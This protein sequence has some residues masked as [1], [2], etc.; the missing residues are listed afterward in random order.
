MARSIGELRGVDAVWP[1]LLAL[2]FGVGC[3]ESG[4]DG[5][6]S[7]ASGAAAS[8]QGGAGAAGPA[9]GSG[10][11]MT[12]TA[13]VGPSTGVGGWGGGGVIPCDPPAD[14]GSIWEKTAEVYAEI[15]PV[16]MCKYRGDVL[17][18][19]NGAAL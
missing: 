12:A 9:S 5:P 13:T 10:N 18:I 2:H 8:G 3:S 7:G 6:G 15:D 4:D 14:P 11:P 17:L 1:A 19:F 16:S